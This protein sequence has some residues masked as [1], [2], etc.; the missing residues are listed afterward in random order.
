MRA[1]NCWR[2]G[3]SCSRRLDR[4]P[5]A[6]AFWWPRFVNIAGWFVGEERRQARLGHSVVQ[7]GSDGADG[8]WN[9][10]TLRGR[11]DRIDRLPGGGLEIIDYKTPSV[12]KKEDVE[13]GLEP[14]LPL[15]ALIASQGGFD[16]HSS[17]TGRCGWLLALA[18][19]KRARKAA[20]L[21]MISN[22]WPPKRVRASRSW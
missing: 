7:R 10:F 17:G 12:P 20:G 18:R 5:E 1:R 13:R 2:S 11:A 15:L 16:G 22:G 4:H 9:I 6:R 8:G 14:Q 3:R 19:R 21:S